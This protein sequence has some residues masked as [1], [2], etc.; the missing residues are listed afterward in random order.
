MNNHPLANVKLSA[1]E[2]RQLSNSYPEKALQYA[3][4]RLHKSKSFIRSPLMYITKVA[5]DYC[6]EHNVQYQPS[7]SDQLSADF[8]QQAGNSDF[9]FTDQIS[10]S[11]SSHSVGPRGHSTQR[12]YTYD[13]KQAESWKIRNLSIQQITDD[14]RGCQKIIDNC[15]EQ[16]DDTLHKLLPLIFRESSREFAVARL[17]ELTEEF[18]RRSPEEQSIAE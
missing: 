17:K 18:F 14:M 5:S 16:N 1:D 7:S 6:R 13:S 3:A 9:S 4:A 2:K 8:H 12:H 11:A 10:N 15:K